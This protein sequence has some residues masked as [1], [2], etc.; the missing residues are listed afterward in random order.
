MKLKFHFRFFC[1]RTNQC[2]L[3]TVVPTSFTLPW[4]LNNNCHAKGPLFFWS[5]I[6]GMHCR[7]RSPRAPESVTK[8]MQI[9]VRTLT[10]Q[11]I[12][13]DV[14]PEDSICSVKD[15]IQ[16]LEGIPPDQQRLIFAGWQ[17]EDGRSLHDYNIQM[18]STLHL[19]LRLRGMISTF[20]STDRSDAWTMCFFG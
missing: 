11:T 16:H 8:R 12:T 18:E 13:L 2:F 20:T 3:P 15:K 6:G 10:G 9:F 14:V 7:S 5:F 19:V 1:R 17:L 4:W